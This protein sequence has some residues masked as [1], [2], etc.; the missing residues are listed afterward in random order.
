[1]GLAQTGAIVLM[2]AVGTTTVRSLETAAASGVLSGRTKTFDL[3]GISICC[4]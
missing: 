1:M 2:V 3:R 4:R